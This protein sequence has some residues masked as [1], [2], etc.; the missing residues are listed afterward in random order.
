MSLFDKNKRHQVMNDLKIF[1]QDRLDSVKGGD[2]EISSYLVQVY[3]AYYD[4]GT[5]KIIM[6]LMDAGSLRDIMKMSKKFKSEAPY[7]EEVYLANMAYQVKK[8]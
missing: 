5:I 1:L 6:E 2:P 7:V 4:E 8:V 3:G